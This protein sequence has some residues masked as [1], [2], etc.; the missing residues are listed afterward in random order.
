M[1]MHGRIAVFHQ[2]VC[3]HNP[4][5]GMARCHAQIRTDGQGNVLN[6]R[7][8]A[9]TSAGQSPYAPADLRSAYKITA[10]GSS[11]SIFAV[12]AAYGDLTA[13]TDLAVYRKQYGLPACTHASGCFTVL[14]QNG[15]TKYP[16]VNA[17]WSQERA[18]D[19][20]MV[21]AMCPNCRI[22]LV[23]ANDATTA[24]LAAAVTTAVAKGA[25]VSS[26]IPMAATRGAR[27]PTPRPIPTTAWP[28]LP[29]PETAVMAPA[30][31]PPCPA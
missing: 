14:D 8:T 15:G 7:P 30:F 23:Q 17:G 1:E 21:S 22:M 24:S 18:L 5:P 25:R 13:E 26:P 28:S 3:A 6:I 2:A 12:V 16:K 10:T 29:A 31:R 19:T 11:S 27:R 9:T 20:Q 4:G